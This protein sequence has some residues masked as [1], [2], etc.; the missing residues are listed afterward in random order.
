MGIVTS[1]WTILM[2]AYVDV[3]AAATVTLI[4]SAKVGVRSDEGFH[5]RNGLK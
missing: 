1:F 5:W 4:S 3:S 2:V